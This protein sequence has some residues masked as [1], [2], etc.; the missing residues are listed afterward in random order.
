MA[1]DTSAPE[2]HRHQ[3]LVAVYDG[4]QA[5]RRAVERLI[6]KDFP[7]DTISVLGKAESSG[8]DVLGIYYKDSGERMKSWARQGAAWGALWGLLSAAAGMFVIPGLGTVMLLGPIVEMLVGGAAGAA[9]TGGA[10]AGAAAIS[11]IAVALHRMGVPED[12]LQAYHDAIEQGHYV[13]LLRLGDSDEVARWRP[14]LEWPAPT[15]LQVFAY[16][17]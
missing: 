4:H 3:L 14:E 10:M 17:P 15:E 1:N 7:M 5:A 6:D 11:E 9:L 12:R 13:L 2:H 16:Y 8:D